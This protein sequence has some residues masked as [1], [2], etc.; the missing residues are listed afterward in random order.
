MRATL[1]S[2]LL[3][4]CASAPRWTPNDE[5]RRLLEYASARYDKKAMYGKKIALGT[6]HG[7]DV[8]VEFPCGDV[9]PDYTQRIIHYQPP[10]GSSC[11]QVGGVEREIVVPSFVFT[12]KS[13]CFPRVLVENWKSYY[14]GDIVKDWHDP[15]KE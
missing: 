10:D 11:A 5:D 3:I 1:F 4:A 14:A 15:Q 2:F 13:F 8:V 9:C 7:T 6:N 12:H